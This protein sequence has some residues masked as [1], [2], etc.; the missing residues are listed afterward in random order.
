MERRPGRRL[1]G[2]TPEAEELAQLLRKL[3]AGMTVRE[4][5]D[6]FDDGR[7][8]WNEFRQGRKLI[9]SWLAD[10]LVNELIPGHAQSLQR[11]RGKELLAAAE[12]ASWRATRLARPPPPEFSA[13]RPAGW[14]WP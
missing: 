12:K 8:Q 14:E 3:T 13:R 4:L 2:G 1:D 7:T 10:N 5:A 6:R 11:K 9:P